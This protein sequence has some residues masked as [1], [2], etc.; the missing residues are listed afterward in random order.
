M[1]EAPFSINDRIGTAQLTVRGS[2]G[3]EFIENL[4][5]AADQIGAILAGVNLIHSTVTANDTLNSPA[6]AAP[7]TPA[8]SNAWAQPISATPPVAAPSAFTN[9]AAQ[10][11]S[12]QHGTKTAKAGIGQR[13]PWKA[14]MCPSPKGTPDQCQ[15]VWLKQGSPEWAAH[16][17]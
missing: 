1:N 7:V 2:T 6:P 15:P 13:G 3:D 12:C 5:Y 9:A 4:A 16:P 10:A 8:P 11:P 17:A 14:W